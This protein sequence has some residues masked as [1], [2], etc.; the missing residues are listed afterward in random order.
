MNEL[1]QKTRYLWAM[2]NSY[3]FDRNN[4]L[5]N[6]EIYYNNKYDLWDIR[7]KN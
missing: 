7:S 3:Y 1:I 6:S 4:E 5:K 2:L